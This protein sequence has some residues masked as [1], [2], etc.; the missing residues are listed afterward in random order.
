MNIQHH[1]KTS[2]SIFL[3]SIMVSG[4]WMLGKV[5]HVNRFALLGAIF[6]ILWLP[7]LVMLFVLPT[8]SIVMLFK[9]KTNIRSL[10]FYSFIIVVTTL[11]V[12][13][14]SK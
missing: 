1:S 6:E 7:A 9:E 8:I 3:L 10:Y 5:V 2:I 11:L 12:L 13:F 4:Y 14:L